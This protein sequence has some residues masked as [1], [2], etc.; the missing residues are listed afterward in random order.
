MRVP[1]PVAAHGWYAGELRTALIHYKERDRRDLAEPLAQLL[2][3][4]LAVRSS[5]RLPPELS[6]CPCRVG[7]P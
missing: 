6:S 1:A 5:G 3:T 7:A 4:A 2:D